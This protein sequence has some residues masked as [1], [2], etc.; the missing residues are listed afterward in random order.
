MLDMIA[1][2]RTGEDRKTRDHGVKVNENNWSDPPLFQCSFHLHVFIKSIWNVVSS[3]QQHIY[4]PWFFPETFYGFSVI[5]PHFE[6]WVFLRKQ[7]CWWV[8]KLW[9]SGATGDEIL[10]LAESKGSIPSDSNGLRMSRGV[11]LAAVLSAGNSL[12][13]GSVFMRCLVQKSPEFVG[14]QALRKSKC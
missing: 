13:M 3:G 6:K 14:L 9:P 10:A 5:P 8:G 12:G 4:S 11:L 1:M 2:D 7:L